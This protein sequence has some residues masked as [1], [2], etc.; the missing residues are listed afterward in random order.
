MSQFVAP[1]QIKLSLEDT[2]KSFIQSTQQAFQSNTQVILN[3]EHQ[4]GQLATTI[5]ER[6]K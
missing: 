3:L 6:E 4:L 5:V 1:Q 2:L